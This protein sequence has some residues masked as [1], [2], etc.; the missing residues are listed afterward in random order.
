M[1]FSED[2][3][4]VVKSFLVRLI[5]ATGLSLLNVATDVN[6]NRRV[7]AEREM[8]VDPTIYGHPPSRT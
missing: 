2:S 7:P 4:N 3:R 6:Q 5:F 1:L 8:V